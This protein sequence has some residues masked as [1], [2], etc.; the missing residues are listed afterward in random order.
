MDGRTSMNGMHGCCL[1]PFNILSLCSCHFAVASKCRRCERHV[2]AVLPR[3]LCAV[4]F[5]FVIAHCLQLVQARCAPPC[6]CSDRS[7]R[8][9][10][11]ISD[12]ANKSEIPRNPLTPNEKNPIHHGTRW[13][14]GEKAT[15]GHNNRTRKKTRHG[16]SPTKHITVRFQEV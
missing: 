1:E 13:L 12:S 11:E 15:D 16:N 14:Q 4:G 5:G 7:G 3:F 9:L 6:F 8:N 10:R 2:Q